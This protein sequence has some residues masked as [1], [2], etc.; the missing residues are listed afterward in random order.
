ML[1]QR[2]HPKTSEKPKFG[3][4]RHNLDEN[5][6]AARI[7][8]T[9]NV[10]VGRYSANSQ[11]NMLHLLNFKQKKNNTNDFGKRFVHQ[12][13]HGALKREH[14]YI[15]TVEECCIE[16]HTQR[17][18][19]LKASAMEEDI[20]DVQPKEM[21]DQRP[22]GSSDNEYGKARTYHQPPHSMSYRNK[23]FPC[24]S[25]STTNF[26]N[27]TNTT[28][29]VRHKNMRITR[30]YNCCTNPSDTNNNGT[31]SSTNRTSNPTITKT[32]GLTTA[33]N[34]R[35]SSRMDHQATKEDIIPR[36]INGRKET[37][38]RV[39]GRLQTAPTS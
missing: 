3:A 4:Q 28:I 9:W 1:P 18:F 35:N 16:T 30:G 12:I 10:V 15:N 19:Y 26:H 13:C 8:I 23:T 11:G 24:P 5:I 20:G 6:S 2:M 22:C 31:I 25:S 27:T 33:E 21:E 37:E 17:H 36:R 32:C 39:M 29:S 7:Q 14:E 34:T 38:K